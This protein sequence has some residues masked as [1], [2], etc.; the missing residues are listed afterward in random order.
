M[1]VEMFTYSTALDYMTQEMRQ[2]FPAVLSSVSWQLSPSSLF[3]T[4]LNT[5]H[6]ALLLRTSSL[7]FS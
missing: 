1:A 7:K 5:K 4:Q 2:K 6:L 3:L